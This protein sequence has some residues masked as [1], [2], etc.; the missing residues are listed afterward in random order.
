MLQNLESLFTIAVGFV[1]LVG[2]VLVGRKSGNCA[3][4]SLLTG[5]KEDV[6]KRFEENREDHRL[7]FSKID[8]LSTEIILTLSKY[9]KE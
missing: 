2:G 6:T 7:L 8:K 1:A 5:L 9:A 4:C 3:S